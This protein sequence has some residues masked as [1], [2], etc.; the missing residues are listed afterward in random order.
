M[1]P[2]PQQRL[3]RGILG[4]RLISQETARVAINLVSMTP[5]QELKF[6]LADHSFK[7]E[8]ETAA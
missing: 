7:A 8:N 6:Q 2:E 4:V 3:L 5:A 1:F